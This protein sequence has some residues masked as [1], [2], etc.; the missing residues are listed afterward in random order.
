MET[1]LPLTKAR[2]IKRKFWKTQ[3]EFWKPHNG[4]LYEVGNVREHSD[5][6]YGYGFFE[7]ELEKAISLVDVLNQLSDLN[8][9]GKL[10]IVERIE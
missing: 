2:E 8:N 1:K 10:W 4:Y 7:H 6:A 3:M 9:T 5:G